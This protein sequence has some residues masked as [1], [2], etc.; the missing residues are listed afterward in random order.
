MFRSSRCG[1]RVF[2]RCGVGERTRRRRFIW[3]VE[4]GSVGDVPVT[5]DNPACANFFE[6]AL[7]RCGTPCRIST[8]VDASVSGHS[9]HLG[10]AC[11][12][13]RTSHSAGQPLSVS[14]RCAERECKGCDN[15][16]ARKKLRI[17]RHS[18]GWL[19]GPPAREFVQV[20]LRRFSQAACPDRHAVAGVTEAHRLRK[21]TGTRTRLTALHSIARV[22]AAPAPQ[23]SKCSWN[24]LAFK[25]E[26]GDLVRTP[27]DARK[28]MANWLGKW[29]PP[30]SSLHV[31]LW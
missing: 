15:S 5:V 25:K 6:F 22:K 24:C 3:S 26:S 1:K 30:S 4:P 18:H 7:C 31:S 11:C 13:H 20:L 29:I 21:L 9:R 10:G 17:R 28:K 14:H 16:T 19:A 2:E 27:C 23:Q 12:R 8:I